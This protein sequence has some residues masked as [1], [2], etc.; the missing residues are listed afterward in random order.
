MGIS[1]PGIGSGLDVNSIVTQLVSIEKQPLTALKTKAAGLQSQ[2]STYAAIKSQV[3]A[4]G[5]AAT[6][7]STASDW[8]VFRATS[9]NAS[10]AT[11]STTSSATATSLSL[12]ISTLARAQTAASRSLA[13]D[14]TLGVAGDVGTLSIA[15]GSWATGSFV[16]DGSLPV[17]VSINGD[18]KLSTI[19]S[20]INASSAGVTATVMRTGTQERLVL[21]SSTTG[22][23]AGFSV[24]ASG[25]SGLDSLSFNALNNPTGSTT[26]MELGQTGLNAVAKLNGLQFESATNTLT[27][28][29]PG[30]TIAL[31]QITTSPIEITVSQDL[32]A[33]QKKI[34]TFADAYT[35]LNKTIT[36][37]LRYVQGGA[38][39]PLQGD[40]TTMGL[41]RVLSSV[42]G[43]SSTGSTF[44][45]LT[46]VGLQRQKDGSLKVDTTKLATAMK[47]LPNVQK[48]FTQNN[49]DT[50]TNGFGLKF[51]DF[52]SGLIAST[53]TITTKA[54]ALQGAIT[55]NTDEQDK[56]NARAARIET[57]LRKQYSDL[58]SRLVNLQGLNSYVTAQLAQWNKTS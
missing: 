9:T 31:N 26:G 42:L 10:A 6:A 56:V 27:D 1:S 22:E 38:S 41:Q 12:E 52:A 23:E 55:R 24:S 53:G 5:D 28:V 50:V 14:G 20:K 17:S 35:A 46:E 19:A 4:L 13:T 54:A 48:L 32:E 40:S 51:K 34:Q 30:V 7:L 11:I 44:S 37:A 29:V 43:S 57:Q 16:D 33:L 36:D 58:D 2:V 21:R 47:D 25:F 15:L 18:D 8:G 45:H 3:S 39:G 49:G